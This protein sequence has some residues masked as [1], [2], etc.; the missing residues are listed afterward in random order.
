MSLDYE[1]FM[2][3]TEDEKYFIKNILAFFNISDTIVNINILERFTSD[4]KI[5]EAKIAYTYQAMMENIHGEMYSLMIETLIKNTQEKNK[6]LD[7]VSTIPCISK[8]AEWAFRW[9]ESDESFAKRL[10]AFAIVEG[11][12]FSGSFCSIFWIKH[13]KKNKMPGLTMSNE[14]IARD[15][16]MHTD[17]ACLLYSMIDSKLSQS[18]IHEMIK[19]AVEIETEVYS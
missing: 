17:F 6:L 9:I 14:F 8:K 16:G 12:F 11:I 19:E 13:I 10:V 3:F 5:M 1:H 18:T 4:V 15:E 7:A 2:D